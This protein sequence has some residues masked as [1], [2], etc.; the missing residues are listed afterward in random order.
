MVG[1]CFV[2]AA[3][4]T[5]QL[6]QHKVRHTVECSAM[7][8]TLLQTFNSQQGSHRSAVFPAS[9]FLRHLVTADLE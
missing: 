8:A 2:G 5:C 1:G 9:C 3:A 6:C 4:A 7:V